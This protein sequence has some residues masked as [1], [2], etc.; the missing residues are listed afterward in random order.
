MPSVDIEK[1]RTDLETKY[2]EKID[3]KK[4]ASYLMYPKVF[5]DFMAHLQ[6]YGDTSI[7]PTELFFY[8]PQV[9]FEYSL[10]IEKGKNLIVRYLAKSDANNNGVRSVFFEINGQPRT[11]EIKDNRLS[12]KI[13][14]KLKASDQNSKH[15]G[16]PLPGQISK[17]FVKNGKRII[18]GDNLLVIEAMKM[19]TTI[20]A[21]KSGLIKS[22]FVAVGENVETKDLLIELD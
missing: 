16:S 12:K 15:I 18:K 20:T 4:L 10:G 13:S 1:E 3:N 8:G 14:Q 21:E 5:E 6:K 19:E 7:L 2:K 11:I 9:D 22:L 17:I